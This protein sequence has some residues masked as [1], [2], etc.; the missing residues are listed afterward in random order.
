MRKYDIVY[1]LEEDVRSGE[2]RYSLRSIEKNMTHGKVWFYC[3]KPEGI[4]PDEYVPM[5][6]QGFMKWEKAKSSLIRACMNDDITEKFWLFN[7]DFF[8]L[9]RMLSIKPLFDGSMHDHILQIEH[10]YNDKKTGYT[11]ML[12]ACEEQ[13]K[14]A[15]CTTFNYAIHVPMLID[16]QQ[17]LEALQMFPSCPMFRCLYGNYQAIGGNGH[18]DVKIHDAMTPVPDGADFVSTDDRAFYCGRV[19]RDLR[20]MF[21]DKCRYE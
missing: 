14:D 9:K 16:R 6:Q 20:N 15:G 18:E 12:R 2:L 4:D 19:G 5:K 1:I 10:R 8:V 3:G 7:D 11:K 13:L 17:M 21:P